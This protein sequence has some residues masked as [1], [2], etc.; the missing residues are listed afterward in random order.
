MQMAL[1]TA[2]LEELGPH[3]AR[4]FRKPLKP[5]PREC[6]V[7]FCLVFVFLALL[8]EVFTFTLSETAISPGIRKRKLRLWST[9]V[10]F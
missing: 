7:Y 9:L 3:M 4:T 8:S 2:R 6:L 1:L 10:C 5:F